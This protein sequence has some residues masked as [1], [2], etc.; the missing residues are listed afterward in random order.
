MPERM[1]EDTRQQEDTLYNETPESA[2]PQRKKPTRRPRAWVCWLRMWGAPLAAFKEMRNNR[3]PAAAMEQEV[4]YPLLALAAAGAFAFLFYFGSESTVASCLISAVTIF[5]S[6]FAS[7]FLVFPFCRL[8]L[9]GD[10]ARRID[11]PF[12]H[13]YVAA[14]MATLPLYYFLYELMPMF[15][16]I[17][18][19]TPAY[20]IYLAVKGFPTL[21][22]PEQ[23][24]TSTLVGLLLLI[25]ALPIIIYELLGILLPSGIN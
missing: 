9:R 14:L 20:T 18:V 24:R 2:R 10:C 21:N 7:Y 3:L 5:V 22:I 23:R 16:A 8:L 11:T 1:A 15:E 6:C 4:F 25:I 13:C 17:F 12:G 19:F